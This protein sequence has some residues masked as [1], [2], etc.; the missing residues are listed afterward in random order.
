MHR[1]LWRYGRHR[2]SLT[3]LPLLLVACERQPLAP[4]RALRPEFA[5]TRTEITDFFEETDGPADCTANPRIGE[6]VLF[7]GRINYVLRAT[8]T[9]SG[10]VDT[11]MQFFYDPAVHLVG[12]T[13]GTVWMINPTNT[14]PILIFLFHGNGVVNKINEHEFYTNGAGAHLMLVV[15]YLVVA[16]ANGKVTVSR[17]F[18]YRCVGG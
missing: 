3:L 5:A 6:I 2:L 15:N 11:T 4:D 9:P 12:Q 1:T 14:Q 17:D 18:V 16:N 7:T 10:N 13:S 8:T